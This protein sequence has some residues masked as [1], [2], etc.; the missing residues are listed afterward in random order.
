M[1]ALDIATRTRNGELRAMG[2]VAE[3][4]ASLAGAG[5]TL[6]AFTSL[7]NDRAMATATRVDEQIAAGNAGGRLAGVPFG[8]KEN[9]DVAGLTT[10]AGSVLEHGRPA[11]GRDAAAIRRLEQAGAV[12]VGT[13]N[14]DEYAYGFTT[15]NSHRGPSRNPHDPSRVAG[16]SSGGSA[17]A[18]AAGL[19][20]LALGTDTN[21]SVR[22]PS[23]LC[24]I[25]GLKPTFGRVSRAGTLPFVPSLDTVGIFAR[26]V[27]DLAVA[28]DVLAGPGPE[29]A[30]GAI[31]ALRIAVAGGY[32]ER[33]GTSP[34]LRA[35]TRVASAL[36]ASLRLALP[37][38]GMA[39]AAAFVVTAAE[40]AQL[41]LA[42]LRERAKDFDPMTRYRFIAGALLPADAYIA[43]QRARRAWCQEVKEALAQADVL[44][45]PATPFTAPLIGQREIG[46]DD[47]TTVLT[48]PYL[49]V[50][51][52]PVSFAGLPVVSV[53]AGQHDGLPVGVQL[54]ARPFAEHSALAVAAHLEHL[55]YVAPPP[56]PD[57]FI[58]R[59]QC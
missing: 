5:A 14:M 20:P 16:G 48:Q 55:G 19:V 34:C 9:F 51:T 29:D 59:S 3:A 41:R 53:P 52:Q 28:F 46:L 58:S 36:G 4:L 10:L 50:Y 33:G 49:G 18:V 32:F 24:G 12:L 27:A 37:S 11:A 15:E 45:A 6:N 17:A 54:I 26:N 23:A 57:L 2:V 56:R 13:T 1:T 22:V 42:D 47:G 21:G 40:G 8:A 39:R 31:G 35:V 25:F 30:S 38:A 44:L 43:A 7:V